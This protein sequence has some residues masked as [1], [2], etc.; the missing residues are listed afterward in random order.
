[1]KYRSPIFFKRFNH[2]TADTY[3]SDDREEFLRYMSLRGFTRPLNVWFDNLLSIID[4]PIDPEGEWIARLRTIIYPPDADWLFMNIRTMH[5]A[6]VTPSDPRDEFILT[7]NAFGIH[8]GPGSLTVDRVIG[9]ETMTV[10]TEFHLLNVISPRLAMILRHN[11]L[12]EPLEDVDPDVRNRKKSMRAAQASLHTDPD[13]ATSLLEDLPVAKAHNSYTVVNNGRLELAKG[14]DGKPRAGHIFD[15]VFFPLS[16]RHAQMLNAVM[17]DQAHNTSMLIFKS[18]TALRTALEFYLGYPA[19]AKGRHSMKTITDRKNDP[20]LILFRKLEYVAQ[21]LG[22]D[23]K[24]LY[25]VDPLD[26]E[27]DSGLPLH[28]K[29]VEQGELPFD[30]AVAYALR[31]TKPVSPDHTV[32]LVMNVLVLVLTK[33]GTN[34]RT[35]YVLD[36]M[37]ENDGALTYPE[38]VFRSVFASNIRDFNLHTTCLLDT[39][40]EL[41]KM[42][43]SSLVAKAIENSGTDTRADVDQMWERLARLE[44]QDVADLPPEVRDA[45]EA[46]SRG[47]DKPNHKKPN[48]KSTNEAQ[49]SDVYQRR[50]NELVDAMGGDLTSPWSQ[51]KD[52]ELS[53]ACLEFLELANKSVQIQNSQ[54]DKQ[55][56]SSL[57]LQE[58]PQD[59]RDRQFGRSMESD[60]YEAPHP[61]RESAATVLFALSLVYLTWWITYI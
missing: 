32:M 23:V 11:S 50:F 14:E 60:S 5:L 56:A 12:P 20:M 48:E 35:T 21:S 58:A 17:L 7:G 15:F 3:D 4:A 49:M 19:Q 22:S 13:H 36:T 29:A 45:I 33:T 37:F 16:S 53:I 25:H 2:Q 1:M 26:N 18:R 28:N 30:E 51:Q 10:Y 43:W 47:N 27:R 34:I 61:F 42:C 44:D 38:P 9:K 41:W 57:P 46:R 8:E 54:H 59:H 24:A 39:D 55:Y 40:V 52:S 31:T 6:F